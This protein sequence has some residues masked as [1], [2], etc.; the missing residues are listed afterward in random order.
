MA[1]KNPDAYQKLVQPL[2]DL[3]EKEY[4]QHRMIIRDNRT[5]PFLTPEL[6]Q[7][8]VETV[9]VY[10]LDFSTPRLMD[11]LAKE[12]KNP[13]LT[14]DQRMAAFSQVAALDLAHQ[15]LPEAMEKYGMMY[16]YYEKKK[17]APM[18]AISLTGA[19]DVHMRMEQPKEAL[20]RYQQGLALAVPT[21][22]LPVILNLLIGAGDAN[23][24]LGQ[25]ADAEGYYKYANDTAGK[26][27]NVFSKCDILEKLGIARFKGGKPKEAIETWQTGKKLSLEFGYKD[28][29]KSILDQLIAVYAESRQSRQRYACEAEKIAIDKT[30]AELAH[31]PSL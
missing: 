20:E 12:T 4:N 27:M 26:T 29:A 23:L 9:L 8:N 28:R 13:N 10:D 2:F 21:K 15:R 3:D 14:P 22:N 31:E 25:Y 19:G 5:T 11:S 17:D 16:T 30:T 7:Q 24:K 1:I 6:A 18:Q